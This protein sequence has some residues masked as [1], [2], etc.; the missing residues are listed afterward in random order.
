MKYVILQ[1]KCDGFT[2][3]YP[4]IFAE[5]MTHSIIAAAAIFAHMRECNEELSVL[6]AGFCNIDARG[7]Y[8]CE[9][10]SESLKIKKDKEVDQFDA[11]LLNLPNAM[12]G[13]I[14]E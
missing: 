6:T 14:Y 12:Q 7:N 11:D 9:H 4:L 13:I 2:R 1:K 8:E 10:G 5:Y 3:V